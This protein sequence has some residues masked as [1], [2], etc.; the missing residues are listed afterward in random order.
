MII[1][2]NGT[3]SAGKSTLACELQKQLDLPVFYFSID[4]LLYSLP[5][6]IIKSIE[7]KQPHTAQVDWAAIFQ[8][9][10]DC[11]AALQK[12]GNTVIADCPVYNEPIFSF[13]QNSLKSIDNKFVFGVICSLDVLKE[14]ELQRKDRVIGLA[15]KQFEGIHKYLTYN[16]SMDSSAYEAS[17]MAK[18]LIKSL[19]Q[20]L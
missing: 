14:R 13:Y 18:E 10:F 20:K 11:V 16:L 5:P 3:S 19:N 8:G 4:T 6:Q 7:G 17:A 15:E 2:L 9:Y 12:A 1:Y